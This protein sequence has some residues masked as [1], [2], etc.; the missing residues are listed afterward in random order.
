ME[1]K[2]GEMRILITH[3]G[4]YKVFGSVPLTQR[5]PAMSIHGEPL[6]WDPVG[7]QIDEPAPRRQYSL[8][9]CGHSQNKPFCDGSHDEYGIDIELIADRR[10]RQERQRV[11]QGPGVEMTDDTTLCMSAGFCGTR[12]IK[13][14]DMIKRTDDPEILARLTRMVSNCPSGRLVYALAGGEPVEPLYR[15]SIATIPDGPLWVRGGIPIETTD[16]FVYEVRNR[17]TL[18]RCGK[19]RNMPFCDGYHEKIHFKAP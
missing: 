14:W 12:F 13:V 1:N 17:V 8:C 5:Y 11:Y 6:E 7:A 16:G 15:P 9:R 3:N 4:P 18:C 19:S 10:L 2:T